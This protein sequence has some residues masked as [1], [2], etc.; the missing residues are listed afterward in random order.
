MKDSKEE[1]QFLENYKSS[2]F[3]VP[4]TTVDMAIFSIIDRKLQILLVSRDSLPEKDNIALP[5]GFIDLKNDIDLDQTALR[6]LHEKTGVKLSYLEQVETVGNSKRDPRGWAVTI[7]YFA[8]IDATKIDQEL[9]N[10]TTWHPIEEAKRM[11]LAFDHNNLLKKAI[12]RLRAKTLYT[13]L[14]IALLP[15]KFTLTELQ[16]IFEIILS[17]KLPVKSFRRRLTDAKAVIG[18]NE[19]KI[20]GKRSAQLFKSTGLDK[21]FHFPRPLQL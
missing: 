14:P 5:G 11:S 20:S 4:L 17:K 18:T 13:A 16:T 1:N 3:D 19:S 12:K 2:D 8:L 10:H 7:L 9:L 15:P 6:K 21:D